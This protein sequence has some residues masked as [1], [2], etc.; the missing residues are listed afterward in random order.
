MLLS[1]Q[2]FGLMDLHKEKEM[3]PQY[4]VLT[5]TARIGIQTLLPLIIM[6]NYVEVAAPAS[7]ARRSRYCSASGS[8]RPPPVTATENGHSTR[9]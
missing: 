4:V 8:G 9:S 7:A 3:H 2:D 6:S 5:S 1:D